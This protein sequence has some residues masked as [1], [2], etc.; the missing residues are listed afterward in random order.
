MLGVI[1]ELPEDF[2]LALVAVDIVGLSYREAARLLGTREATITS[3]LYRARRQ[4]AGA[5]SPTTTSA[6]G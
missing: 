3:R 2:R 5:L 4:V 6:E 1:A